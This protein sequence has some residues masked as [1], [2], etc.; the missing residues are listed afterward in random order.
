MSDT[1]EKDALD[2]RD[3]SSLRVVEILLK[4]L[5]GEKLRTPDLAKEFKVGIR[6]IQRD[7]KDRLGNFVEKKNGYYFLDE[8]ILSNLENSNFKDFLQ[9]AKLENFFPNLLKGSINDILI[10]NKKEIY[11]IKSEVGE[12]LVKEHK[13]EIFNLLEFAIKDRNR[14]TFTY[15]DKER[16]VNPYK[17]VNKN[18]IW[19]LLALEKDKLKYFSL[20]RMENFAVKEDEQFTFKSECLELIE[21]SA[22]LNWVSAERKQAIL[23]LDF[24]KTDKYYFFRK[25]FFPNKKIVKKD[26]DGITFS[27]EYSYDAEIL[28]TIIQWLPHITIQSPLSLK[29]E[30]L[31][32]L[33]TYIKDNK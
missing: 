23:E 6:T 9:L 3:K 30:L 18:K 4:L 7:F 20:S 22:D 1:N 12:D 28:R 11:L 29:E 26:D 33:K 10:K 14:V 5:A 13:D 21:N 25:D 17:L 24:T 19:Y 16:L 2:M 27:V 8:Y 32:I 15:K 31:K